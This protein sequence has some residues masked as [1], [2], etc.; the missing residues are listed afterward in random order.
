LHRATRILSIAAA[1][2]AV[3]PLKNLK[4]MRDDPQATAAHADEIKRTYSRY[5]G[6]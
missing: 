4:L 2:L 3:S 6:V 1:A 5:F